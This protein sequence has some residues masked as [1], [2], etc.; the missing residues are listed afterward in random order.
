[1][2]DRT[3]RT[4]PGPAAGGDGPSRWQ[5]AAA[6]LLLLIAGA[7]LGVTVDRLWVA[8]P[9]PAAADPLTADALARSLELGPD[10][11]ARVRALLDSLRDDVAG[12]AAAGPDSLRA[13]ARAARRR[14]HE[15]LPPDRRP[16]FRRWMEHRHRQMMERMH[17]GGRHP[18]H[19]PGMRMRRD[20]STPGGMPGPG[21]M[22]GGG[23]R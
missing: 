6:G 4:D 23:R 18:M 11:R 8:G 9:R 1:M 22:M 10:D 12:A 19:G 16:A 21:P 5:A 3:D 14:L 15:A 17:P 13:A 20:D 2:T 7:A